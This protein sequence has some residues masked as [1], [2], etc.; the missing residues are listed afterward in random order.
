MFE[1]ILMIFLQNF[2]STNLLPKYPPQR[3]DLEN[4]G[5]DLEKNWMSANRLQ[6]FKFTLLLLNINCLAAHKN[7]ESNARI[8]V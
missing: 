2:C 4:E 7:E 6:M 8:V 3:L 5:Q 1:T